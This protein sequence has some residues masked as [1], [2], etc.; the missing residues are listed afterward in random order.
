M[1]Y[2]LIYLELCTP[3]LSPKFP[4]LI[5]ITTSSFTS[6]KPPPH[7]TSYFVPHLTSNLFDSSGIVS[8]RLPLFFIARIVHTYHTSHQY[9]YVWG[10][11]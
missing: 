5:G 2:L 6:H 8:K 10:M 4:P 9:M 3:Y 11:K 7:H 1:N